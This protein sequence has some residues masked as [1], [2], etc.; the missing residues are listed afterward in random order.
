MSDDQSEAVLRK[1][2]EER[3]KLEKERAAARARQEQG[4]E[5]KLA[6]KRRRKELEEARQA[7]ASQQSSLAA[8]HPQENTE[9][10]SSG[11]TGFFQKL[12]AMADK[13]IAKASH[14]V[15]AGVHKVE[16]VIKDKRKK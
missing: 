8:S 11:G 12:G 6:E 1:H 14:V 2:E 3:L 15:E 13:G 9:A 16:E 5:E 7:E 10:T 4:L